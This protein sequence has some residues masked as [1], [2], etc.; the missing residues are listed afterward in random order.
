MHTQE[1]VELVLTE[2][3]CNLLVPFIIGDILMFTLV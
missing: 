2:L 1:A 3:G